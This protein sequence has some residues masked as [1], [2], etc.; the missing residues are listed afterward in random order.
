MK[1]KEIE[2]IP[3]LTLLK[4]S[5]KKGAE[6]IAVTA[7]KT[8][9]KEKHLFLEVYRNKKASKDVPLVRIVLTKK[10]F[11]NFFPE[12]GE[13]SRQKIVIG[14]RRLLWES[15][16]ESKNTWQQE[17]ARNILLEQSDLHRLKKY[18]EKKIWDEGEWWEYVLDHEEGILRGERQRADS[19]RRERRMQALND[20]IAHTPQLPEKKILEMVD[21]IYYAHKHYLYYKKRGSWAQ[22]ACTKCGG[23]TDARW[24]RGISYE[25]QF[26]RWTEEPRE[27]EVGQCPLCKTYGEWK[28]QGKAKPGFNKSMHIFWGQKYKETGFIMRYIEVSKEWQLEQI[29]GEKDVEMFNASEELSGIEIARAYFETGKPVQIDFHKQNPYTGKDFW[30]DCNLYG[31]AY[32][33]IKSAPIMWQTYAEIQGTILQYSALEDFAAAAG[34]VNA[35]EYLKAYINMPQIEMLVKLNLIEVVESLVRGSSWGVMDKH[36]KRPDK[37]L[38]IRK[39]RVRQLMKSKGSMK[40]LEVMQMEKRMGQI[41]TDRQIEHLGETGLLRG[42][43]ETAMQYMSMQQLLNR[44]K[45][46]ADCEYGT[47][48]SR[49]TERIHRIAQTYI[50][51]LNM[52]RELGYDLHNTVYQQPRSLTAA[53]EKMIMERDKKWQ[54]KRLE[55]VKARFPEIRKSY[56]KLRNRYFYEDENYLI[57]PARSAEEIVME[58]RILHHCVGGDDY[59]GKHNKG[60]SYILMLRDKKDPEMPYITVEID[61]EKTSI[62]QWYGANDKKPDKENMDRWLENYITRLKCG[63]LEEQRIILQAM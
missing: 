14:S 24:K 51:Y 36:A 41:W 7:I 21:E 58:G 13:W 61:G 62:K 19:R 50:D 39:E 54:D 49:A 23:V 18:S 59:L 4:T 53:H 31:N 34:E 3:Y 30:D 16:E 28:C 63:A 33:S 37:F 32:I 20:R 52:R 56:R 15:S 1:K 2:K 57:R 6:Y 43:V 12:P 47:G 46:Y 11:G 22:I 9:A 25:S 35:I 42:A 60:E 40:L 45:K 5:R 26:Q 17:K 29:C 55:E 27:G 38:G 44:I 8:I 10:D 48:C